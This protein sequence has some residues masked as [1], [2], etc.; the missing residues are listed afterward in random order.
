MKKV[1]VYK[2]FKSAGWFIVFSDASAGDSPYFFYSKDPLKGAKPL[3]AWS[4]A[5]TIFETSEVAEW[6]KRNAPDI[7]ERLANC[8]AWYVTLSPE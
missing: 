2:A 6:V 8:F 5:A 3:T 7:P 1:A 4:G